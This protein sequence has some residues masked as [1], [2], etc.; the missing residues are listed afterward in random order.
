MHKCTSDKL[1]QWEKL[2]F[3]YLSGQGLG[4]KGTSS[5]SLIPDTDTSID[6]H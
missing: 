1:I 2:F 4:G 3:Y 6:N 5:Q